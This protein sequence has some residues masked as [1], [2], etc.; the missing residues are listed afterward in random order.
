MKQKTGQEMSNGYFPG[1][2]KNNG[3]AYHAAVQ[4]S[5]TGNYFNNSYSGNKKN[6]GSNKKKW[7]L[8]LGIAL[9]FAVLAIMMVRFLEES[10]KAAEEKRILEEKTET[11]NKYSGI[12]ADNIYIEGVNISGKTP[13][14]AVTLISQK[15]YERQNSWYLNINYRGHTFFTLNYS[16]MGINYDT[17]ELNKALNDAFSI[18]HTGDLETDYLAIINRENECFEF[19]STRSSMNTSALDTYLQQIADNIA[20]EPSDAFLVSF[21]PDAKEPFTI[22]PEVYGK[23]LNISNTKDQIINA[24]MNGTTGDFELVPDFVRPEVTEGDIRKNVS[25]IGYAETPV[26]AASTENRTNNIRLAFSKFNGK[27]MQPNESF[28]F[29]TVCG[30]RTTKNGYLD[31]P[32]YAYNEVVTEIGGGVCQASSTLYVAACLSNLNITHREPHS[33]AVNYTEYGLDAT[34]NSTGKIIDLTFANNTGGCIYLTA[35]VEPT[36]NKK[37][38]YKCVVCIYGPAFE[39]GVEYKMRTEEVELIPGID[40]P[41]IYRADDGTFGL[42]YNDQ[43]KLYKAAID[44][45]VV[46]TYLQ[47]WQNGVLVEEKKISEDEYPAQAEIYYRGTQARP[48]E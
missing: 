2:T 17:D 27:I 24:M 13:E 37:Q 46:V 5:G 19:N 48:V 21:S 11:V 26:N 16:L 8:I 7:F 6:N 23:K 32:A 18:G 25:L 44:G 41:R 39:E 34:V 15:I 45:H 40:L 1:N 3:V 36:N 35:H 14:E 29:N 22:M 38:P 12:F 43:E 10:K 20:E 4:N 33:M 28:S 42:Q 30:K 9:L 47:K 31:A